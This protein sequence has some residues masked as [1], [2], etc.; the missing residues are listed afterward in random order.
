LSGGRAKA[1][2]RDCA[3]ISAGSSQEGH[4]A[5]AKRSNMIITIRG[6]VREGL[7]PELGAAIDN[8]GGSKVSGHSLHVIGGTWEELAKEMQGGND[9]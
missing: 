9:G 4:E 7:K 8:F 3:A 1:S 2:L 6:G 5:P